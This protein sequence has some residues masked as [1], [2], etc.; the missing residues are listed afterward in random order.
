MRP[1]KKVRLEEVTFKEAVTG[2]N[3][4]VLRAGKKPIKKIIRKEDAQV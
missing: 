2:T 4:T 3:V 1:E